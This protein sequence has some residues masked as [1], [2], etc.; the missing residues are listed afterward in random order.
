MDER[1]EATEKGPSA[2]FPEVYAKILKPTLI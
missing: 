2:I 1:S